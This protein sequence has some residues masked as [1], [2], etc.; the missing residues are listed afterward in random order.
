[1]R[2]ERLIMG[3]AIDYEVDGETF[4]GHVADGSGGKPAP[5]VV[6]FHEAS[7]LGAHARDK[8]ELLAKAG[9]VALAADL[10][11]GVAKDLSE[12][13]GYITRLSSE[14]GLLR[15][16]CTAAFDLLAAQPN[17]D[18]SR[19]AAIGFCFG[20]QAALELARSGAALKAVV[21]FHSGLG[22]PNPESAR[23]IQGKVL[24]CIGDAD[25]LVSRKAR[26][27]FMDDMN[28]AGVDCQLLTFAGVGHSFTNV[29][30]KAFGVAGCE[31]DARAERR[32]WAAMHALFAEAF[33]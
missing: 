4:V 2:W 6:V 1:M 16:R 7:G 32:S 5:G 9:Y 18:A 12:A 21:G 30:A 13:T 31:Y 14:A 29:D 33:A 25:P 15:R 26:D 20:G 8:A 22:K 10:F 17:V 19:M 28:A 24:L 27:D 11:G 23:Q 3:A